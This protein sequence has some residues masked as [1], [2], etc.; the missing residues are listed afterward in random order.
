MTPTDRTTE[1]VFS[2]VLCFAI[3]LGAIVGIW[4]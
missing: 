4:L 1:Y 3:I 2:F